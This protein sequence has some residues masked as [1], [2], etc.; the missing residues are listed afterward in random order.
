MPHS[1][2]Q[3]IFFHHS[4][5]YVSVIY[6]FFIKIEKRYSNILLGNKIR[7]DSFF[8]Q[9]RKRHNPNRNTR[10]YEAG[11]SFDEFDVIRSYII[12]VF[13]LLGK[14]RRR[15][16][17]HR[18]L[19]RDDNSR[20]VLKPSTSEITRRGGKNEILYASREVRESWREYDS[21]IYYG[22]VK[23]NWYRNF[24]KKNT[25]ILSRYKMRCK[26]KLHLSILYLYF[27]K[28]LFQKY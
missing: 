25:I 3:Y 13:R 22:I 27:K 10:R 5:Q 23:R 19:R 26:K 4:T 15:K 2:T 18:V 14:S 8:N 1:L 9:C 28:H 17:C 12:I 20:M 16:L 6:I 24:P 21:V 7:N 11:Y